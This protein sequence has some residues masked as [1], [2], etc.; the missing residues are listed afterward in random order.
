VQPKLRPLPLPDNAK[1]RGQSVAPWL[2]QFNSEPS[3]ARVVVDGDPGK[4]CLTPCAIPLPPGRHTLTVTSANYGM[5]HRIIQVP[6]QRKVFVPLAQNLGIVQV[7]SIPN[8]ATVYVDGH[9]LGQTPATIKLP[10]GPHQ[11]RLV[12]GER[13]HQ[14][15]ITVSADTLQQFTFRWQ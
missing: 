2:V 13:S 1:Q 7:D 12:S 5:A 8:G 9:L 11:I 15:T 10:A 14:E 3:N 6:D 4:T